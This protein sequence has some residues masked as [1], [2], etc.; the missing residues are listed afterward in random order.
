MI[1]L[2]AFQNALEI[3]SVPIGSRVLP[4]KLYLDISA[5]SDI[6]C[7]VVRP[8]AITSLDGKGLHWI[9]PTGH[10]GPWLKGP[11]VPV[12]QAPG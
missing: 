2:R 10:R 12:L 1:E 6:C 9:R 7:V 5:P 11:T 8:P 4:K 3:D